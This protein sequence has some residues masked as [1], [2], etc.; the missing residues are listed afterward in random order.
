MRWFSARAG[1]AGKCCPGS[2]F[3]SPRPRSASASWPSEGAPPPNPRG[4]RV[5]SARP[6][7][8]TASPVAAAERGMAIGIGPV[9]LPKYLDRPQIVTFTSPYALNVA[10]FDRWAE[11]LES[12]FVR[13]LAENLALL[14][15]TARVVVSPWPGS[16][17]LDYQVT[18]EVSDFS[19][20]LG[21]ESSLMARWS[22]FR[23]E[24]Q[25][26]LVSRRSRFKAPAGAPGY[27]AMVAAMSQTLDARD[28]PGGGG[29]GGHRRDHPGPRASDRRQGER[30][31]CPAGAQSRP[32][33]PGHALVRA[34]RRAGG[35][36]GYRPHSSS[37]ART[38]GKRSSSWC[39]PTRR[40]AWPRP[41]SSRSSR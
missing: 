12:T 11:P 10:E 33:L 36:G 5:L 35:P 19:G 26:A 41:T 23:G 4:S 28:Q 13:V 8:G 37:G 25:E 30:D 38:C 40:S 9:T 32:D 31:Q 15:P 18:V 34:G 27:E 7:G 24:G 21:G 20:Q 1:T 6:G 22:L 17:P 29:P 14:L 39:R 3:D 2:S 16:T